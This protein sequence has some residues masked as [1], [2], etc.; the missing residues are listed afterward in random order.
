MENNYQTVVDE[1]FS[2][3]ELQGGNEYIGEPVTILEHSLQSGQLALDA[4]ESPLVVLAAFFHD[5]GHLLPMEESENM[6]GMGH[7]R[8]EILGAEF[9]LSK[10][11]PDEMATLV[12]NHVQAKRY[13][14]FKYPKYYEQLS[15]ASKTTLKYQGGV[16]TPAEAEVFE[17][18]PLFK[19]SLQ[20]RAWDEQAKLTDCLVQPLDF[21]KKLLLEFI[22]IKS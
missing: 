20:L 14:T 21:Y 22:V 3:F 10:G 9:L 19:K 7:L 2:L 6:E 12:K 18:H 1:I 17:K 16:M 15:E 8:H 13:L 5:I 4:E 11:L